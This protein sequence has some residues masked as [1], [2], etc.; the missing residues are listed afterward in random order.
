MNS[1]SFKIALPIIFTGFFIIVVFIALESNKLDIGFYIVLLLLAVYIFLFGFAIGQNFASPVK[2][3]LKRAT[4]LSKGDLT[5]RVYSEAKDE[6]GELA[7]IFNK[8]A[9]ELEESRS[10]TEKAE[11]SVDIKVRARTQA[12]EE[13]ICALEQKVENRTKEVERLGTMSESFRA[14]AKSREIEIAELKK[15]L[16]NLKSK[17]GK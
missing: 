8:I 2:R 6:F 15:E 9:E 1:I 16:D 7:K 13:T 12:I 5:T 4:E 10:T 17:I 3:L 11:K 14:I